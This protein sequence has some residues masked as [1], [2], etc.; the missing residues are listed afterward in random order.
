[1]ETRVYVDDI[2]SGHIY[3]PIYTGKENIARVYEDLYMTIITLPHVHVHEQHFERV[4]S[5]KMVFPL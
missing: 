3:N 2:S 1:M 5:Q 4:L